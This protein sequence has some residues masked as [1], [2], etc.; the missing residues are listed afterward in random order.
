M[1][2][3]NA[4]AKIAVKPAPVADEAQK[5][6]ENK[7]TD[8]SEN[9]VTKLVQAPAPAPSEPM[10]RFTIDVSESLHKRIKMHCAGQGTKMAD[11]L[12]DMLEREFP[13]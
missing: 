10:K 12:R 3:S 13:A 6:V 1:K 5:W 4:F 9:N 7:T 2:K 11:V 8:V